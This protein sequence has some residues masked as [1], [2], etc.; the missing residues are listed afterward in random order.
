M[1][2]VPPDFSVGAMDILCAPSGRAR[3]NSNLSDSAVRLSGC[4]AN[5]SFAPS[6]GYPL[7]SRSRTRLSVESGFSEKPA[8]VFVILFS[9]TQDWSQV[10]VRLYK[11]AGD[12]ARSPMQDRQ[13]SAQAR[14]DKSSFFTAAV[15][16]SR[17]HNNALLRSALYDNA[18]VVLGGFLSLNVRVLSVNHALVSV[19]LATGCGI[20]A[21]TRTSA[22]RALRLCFA[23]HLLREFVRYL[24][25]T[26]PSF[27]H[28]MLVGG[29][30]DSLGIGEEFSTSP[31]SEPEIL[32]P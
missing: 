23:V 28:L 31:R 27:V 25:Q 26:F 24:R 6:T 16:C 5:C 21:A 4:G 30:Q 14:A 12:L 7:S 22:R 18:D 32:S 8:S 20:G 2:S 13:R 17:R 19:G 9:T 10:G 15:D 1:A 29:L 11:G 3:T